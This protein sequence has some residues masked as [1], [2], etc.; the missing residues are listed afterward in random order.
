M[1][2]LFLECLAGLLDLLVLA[3]DFLVLVRQQSRLF[4][5]LLV[6]LLQF[7]LAALQL[8]GERLRLRQQVFGAHVGGDRVDHDADRL[9]E[10]VEEGLVRRVESLERRELED[11]AHF[12]FEHHRQHQHVE[13][14]AFAQARRDAERR[15]RHIRQQDLLLLDRALADESLAELDL[16]AVDLLAARRVAREQLEA[17]RTTRRA[18]HVELGLLRAD[19]RRELGQDQLADG[20][21]VLLAL[22]HARELREVGL[23]PVLLGV[24]L[25]RVLQ[26]ADHLVDRVLQR[27]DFALRFDGDRTRQVAL[28]HRGR[29]LGNRA[30]LRCQIRREV[31]DVLGQALPRSRRARHLGLAAEL[32]FDADFARDRR[33]LIG[34]GRKRCGHAVDRVGQRGDLAFGFHCQ[35]LLQVAVGHGG[36]DLGDAAHLA[37]QVAGHEVHVV[38]EVLP[39]ARHAAHVGLAAQL[40]FGAHLARHARHFGRK[41][42]ELVHHRPAREGESTWTTGEL[43]LWFPPY[44]HELYGHIKELKQQ[45]EQAKVALAEKGRREGALPGWFR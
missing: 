39:G 21:E 30:H 5:Q 2:G 32:A 44:V 1:L 22:Q 9:G 6:G 3:L 8:F 45:R 33:D 16:L 29:D 43:G 14:R 42:F 13:R 25:R 19:H 28:R 31:V 24:L 15:R 11:A 26:V 7:L 40:P 20:D 37:G 35:L 18:Q 38:G 23:Q 36:H 10:L 17:R 12:A 34:E 27:G 41:R 4:L